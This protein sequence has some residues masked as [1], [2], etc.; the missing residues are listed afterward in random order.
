[1]TG[2]T[3]PECR[4]CYERW[5]CPA[6]VGVEEA[7]ARPEDR[8]APLVA[9]AVIVFLLPLATAIAAA[10]LGGR[11]AAPRPDSV[12][13]WQVGGAAGGLLAG[14]VVAR[15]LTALGRRAGEPR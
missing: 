10:F 14:V 15:V 6:P 13:L 1:M 5:H 9:A 8:G 7:A 12:A 3:S 2:R 11:F 4:V